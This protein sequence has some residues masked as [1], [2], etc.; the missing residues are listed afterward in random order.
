MKYILDTLEQHLCI[1]NNDNC[2]LYDIGILGKNESINKEHYIYNKEGNIYY[3][4]NNYNVIDK[5]IIG[6][7]ILS[8]GQ[9]CI[10]NKEKLWKAFS[11]DEADQTHLE[12]NEIND[13]KN[14]NRYIKVGDIYIKNYIKYYQIIV[15]IS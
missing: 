15:M 1:E 10:N 4:D 3:N 8:D 12:C 14:D 9:P 7:L 5:K 6:S 2:P 13:I 11:L